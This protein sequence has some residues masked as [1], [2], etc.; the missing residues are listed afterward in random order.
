MSRAG[1][2][3]QHLGTVATS[4]GP[5]VLSSSLGA[6]DMV[7]ADLIAAGLAL[8]DIG[9]VSLALAQPLAAAHRRQPHGD[10]SQCCSSRLPQP[11][12]RSPMPQARSA[13]Q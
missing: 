1:Q 9:R 10:P 6:E 13:R 4:Y 11:A 3:L 5:A 7:L 2:A 12:T 8:N